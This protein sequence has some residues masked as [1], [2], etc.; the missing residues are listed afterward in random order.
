MPTLEEIKVRQ[1]ATWSSGAYDKIAWLT[2]P[3]A[4]IL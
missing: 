1:Q 2:P 3:L 4:D